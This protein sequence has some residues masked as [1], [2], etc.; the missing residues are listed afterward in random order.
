MLVSLK[1]AS[2]DA[3]RSRLSPLR[4]SALLAGAMDARRQTMWM[5]YIR[6]TKTA[7]VEN[8]NAIPPTEV[9]LDWATEI[10][11]DVRIP[12]LHNLVQDHSLT[13]LNRLMLALILYEKGEP[14]PYD[15]AH[16]VWYRVGRKVEAYT[17]WGRGCYPEPYN[18]PSG[19]WAPVGHF[20]NGRHVLHF[21]GPLAVGQ[22]STY[23]F[24][25]E[26]NPDF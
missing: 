16:L 8:M 20:V 26:W 18:V 5:R 15:M 1:T 22:P 24:G 7:F 2:L 13:M 6:R 3:K 17:D 4:I 23:P 25:E 19:K 9:P 11:R 12:A 10:L 21:L 14:V